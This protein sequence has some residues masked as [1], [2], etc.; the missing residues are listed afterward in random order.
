MPLKRYMIVERFRN[1][2]AVPVYRRFAEQG[3]MAPEGLAYVS[4]WVDEKLDCCFQLMETHDPALLDLWMTNWRDLVD[5]KVHAV[6]SSAEAL[7]KIG[8]QL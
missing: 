4:S 8:P 1:G 7:E 5:F 2:D 3:R 6:I